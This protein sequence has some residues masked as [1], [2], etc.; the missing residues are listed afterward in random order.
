MPRESRL[1][2][3]VSAKHF[4]HNWA[5]LA[6]Q[7]SGHTIELEVSEDALAIGDATDNVRINVMATT[8]QRIADHLDALLLTPRL[9]DL[10]R[11]HAAV[12]L[13]PSN[14][15]PGP[16]MASLAWMIEHSRAVDQKKAASGS[17]GLVSNAGKDWVLSNRLLAQ[18][19]QSAN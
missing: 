19:T 13:S 14:R 18:P 5:S 2:E 7:H 6:V 17:S 12:K 15:T 8:A 10:I 16:Q 9:A 4:V 11:E 3:L 1:L